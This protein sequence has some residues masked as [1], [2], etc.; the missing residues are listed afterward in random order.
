MVKVLRLIIVHKNRCSALENT[1]LLSFKGKSPHYLLMVLR[2]KIHFNY[3]KMLI[4]IIVYG[5]LIIVFPLIVP[6][7]ALVNSNSIN[8]NLNINCHKITKK[9]INKYFII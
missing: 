6:F 2:F 4:W 3:S 7:F 8:S 9:K 1:D 5:K